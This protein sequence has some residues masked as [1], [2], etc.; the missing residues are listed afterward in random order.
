[1]EISLCERQAQPQTD[2]GSPHRS[3]W[4]AGELMSTEIHSMAGEGAP[5]PWLPKQWH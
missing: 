1:M 2:T 3:Q 5:V 4:L